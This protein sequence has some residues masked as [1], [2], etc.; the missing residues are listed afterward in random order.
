[1]RKFANIL[2]K[3]EEENMERKQVLREKVNVSIH[4]TFFHFQNQTRALIVGTCRFP[5]GL[6]IPHLDLDTIALNF[7]NWNKKKDGVSASASF[8]GLPYF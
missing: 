4:Y 7:D 3:W 6:D 2:L 1:M 5:K 8:L